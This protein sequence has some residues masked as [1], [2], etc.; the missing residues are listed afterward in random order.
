MV[1]LGCCQFFLFQTVVH[2]GV[3][4]GD[5]CA[6][7]CCGKSRPR[8]GHLPQ[9]PCTLGCAAI[10]SVEC[11]AEM[12]VH[13]S[14][15]GVFGRWP[16]LCLNVPQQCSAQLSPAC[17]PSRPGLFGTSGDL[18][19]SEAAGPLP[20]AHDIDLSSVIRTV[21]YLFWCVLFRGV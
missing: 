6:R 5:S 9:T 7:P 21:R 17:T 14:V 8:L 1:Q 19:G 18:E 3:H 20:T 4:T 12:A 2:E 11:V 16:S 13:P 15:H 10:F